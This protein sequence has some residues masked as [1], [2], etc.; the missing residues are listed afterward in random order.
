MEPSKIKVSFTILVHNEDD[1]LKKLIEQVTKYNTLWDELVIVDDY[2]DNSETINILNKYEDGMA[3]KVYHNKLNNNFANQKNFAASKCTGDYIFNLDADELMPDGFM[4]IYKEILFINPETDAFRLPRINT[5]DGITLK[6][7]ESWRWQIT[8]LPTMVDERA[9]MYDSDL[10]SILKA[11]NLI[12]ND[13]K[14]LIKFLIPIINYPDFQLRIYKRKDN[15]QWYGN[16]HE[17]LMGYKTFAN[18]PME[19]NYSIIHHKIIDRQ[20]SQNNYYNTIRR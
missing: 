1:S 11:F 4:E 8:S 3:V 2:S 17:T 6:H 19:K 14:G 7:V 13:D 18:F 16:V 12:L 10:Y 20:E 9:I 15:I 5:V